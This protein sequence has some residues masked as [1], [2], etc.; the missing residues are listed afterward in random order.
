MKRIFT[1][2]FLVGSACLQIGAQTTVRKQFTPL[3]AEKYAS[4]PTFV[5]P[6]KYKDRV[7]FPLPAMADNS[8]KKWMP[9]FGWSI[10]GW[11]CAN[12]TAVSFA[13][14]YEVQRTTNTATSGNNPLIT[15]N[16]TYH[17]LN[18]GDQAEGGDGQMFVEAFDILKETGG[19]TTTNFG[20]LDWG[21][22]F[23]GWMTG[24]DKYY[25]AMKIRAQEYY[26]LDASVK[27]NE[28]IIKQYLFDHADG[29]PEGGLMVFQANSE[30]MVKG[31]FGGK[32]ILS[33]LGGGGG[34]SLSICGYDDAFN[35]GS[36]LVA[37]NWGD[38]LFWAKY[39][40][41]RAGA[42]LATS[43]GVPFMF[44]KVRQNYSPKLTFKITLTHSQRN[45][46]LIM[47]GVAPSAAAT[48]PTKTKDYAGAFHNSGG[49]FPMMGKSQSATIEIGLDLTDFASVVTGTEA[50]FFLQVISK[51]GTGQIDKLTLMDY[52]SG[53]AKEI[54]STES[55]KP[56]ATGTTLMSVVWNGTPT[57][58]KET[59]KSGSRGIA[60]SPNPAF[61]GQG[62]VRISLTG[63]GAN[64]AKLAIRDAQG[65]PVFGKTMDLLGSASPSGAVFPWNLENSSG[66]RVAPG[67]YYASVTLMNGVKTV[68]TA[69]TKIRVFD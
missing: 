14:D 27:A 58:L 48:A 31:N 35:G 40:L 42:P 45:N 38:G 62:P 5:L 1:L 19:A 65:R 69:T 21:N 49:S 51:G 39:D 64:L 30:N 16:Y 46:I 54:P 29:S 28:E 36:Y 7:A 12:A 56:I 3:S 32:P 43:Q 17:F 67:I 8:T 37:N 34:H 4:I 33:A 10:Q 26:K 63:G 53:Q 11:S 13:Y 66:A 24:Y 52:S 2:G 9:P 23:G 55:N 6:E 22:S 15:Y 47:T 44:V 18:S 59:P 41:F 20:G 68:K 61:L 50:R 57:A 25:Q 60:A